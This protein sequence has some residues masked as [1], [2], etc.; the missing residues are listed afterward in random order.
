MI[1]R[2]YET[3]FANED[4]NIVRV[5]ITALEAHGFHPRKDGPAHSASFPG[6]APK[7]GFAI[8]V[9]DNEAGDARLLANALYEDMT[10]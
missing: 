8:D 7:G 2:E 10:R 9:P 6:V 5:L 1:M 4:L 3:I